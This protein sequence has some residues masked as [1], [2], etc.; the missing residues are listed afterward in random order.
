MS[1]S[2]G[3]INLVVNNDLC[4]GCGLCMYEC[5]NNALSM[6]FDEFGFLIP[7]LTSNCEGDNSCLNVCPFN[8]YPAKEVESEIELS[9][10][11]LSKATKFDEKIGN[12]NGIFVGYANEY[13][14][15]SSSGGIATYVLSSLLERGIVQHVFS[16]KESMIPGIHYEYAVSSSKQELLKTA[17]T[18][19]FPVTLSTVFKQIEELEG[20]VAIVGVGCFVKAIR[21]AQKGDPYLLEKIPFLVGIICG[22]IKSRYFTDYLA[23]KN[24]V[25][26]TKY[27][28]PEFRIKDIYSSASDYSFGCCNKIS[29]LPKT[30][31]MRTIGDMWGTGLFKA[32]ACD[33]CDDVT[34][35]LADIS[36]GDAWF[37][38]YVLDGRG[39]NVVV[40]R[41]YFSDQII[42]DGINQNRLNLEEL[43]LDTFLFS[44]RGSFNHRHLG[45]SYR[46]KKAL[47]QGLVVPPKRIRAN[48]S[49]GLVF[50]FVQYFRMKVRKKS[51]V[52]WKK[53]K[54]SKE[55]D[56]DMKNSLLVLRITTLLY[57]HLRKLSIK[58]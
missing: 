56:K 3:V 43:S 42:R 12:Y 21:L 29:D 47:K 24:G 49:L 30:I 5:P 55:F 38:P 14:L 20:K 4:I 41:S 31:K 10:I 34:T 9:N 46:I 1:H 40:S 18:K 17:K 6:Q 58:F 39:T 33:F 36:L 44:Q 25:N 2:S 45:L 57:H 48:R 54:N 15:T 28:K 22:G 51:H 37:Q 11:F 23:S 52:V 7:V 35:E 53:T 16:V 32:N 13:R 27:C 8:P 26:A 19:Y 50:E